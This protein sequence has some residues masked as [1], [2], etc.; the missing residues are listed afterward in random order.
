MCEGSPAF[1]EATFLFCRAAAGSETTAAVS[2]LSNLDYRH[3]TREV[4]FLGGGGFC[5][6]DVV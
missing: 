2:F 3:V 4:F 1:S 5:L 6:D